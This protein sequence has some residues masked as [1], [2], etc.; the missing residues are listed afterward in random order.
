MDD[1]SQ[2]KFSDFFN[3]QVERKIFVPKE[4]AHITGRSISTVYRWLRGEV[5]PDIESIRLLVRGL[6]PVA[7]DRLLMWFLDGLPLC[8]ERLDAIAIGD[9]SQLKPAQASSLARDTIMKLIGDLLEM[10][11]QIDKQEDES[12]SFTRDEKSYVLDRLESMIVKIAEIKFYQS[13]RVVH[14]KRAK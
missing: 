3:E 9:A 13:S 5:T 12:K 14:R 11:R 1:E 2:E 6:E 7:R 8:I 10:A 4:V